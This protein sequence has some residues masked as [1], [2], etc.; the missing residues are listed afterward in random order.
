[1]IDL[2]GEGARRQSRAAA[3]ID[4]APEE[5]GLAGRVAR[6]QH[7][8]E[9]Q[10]GPTIAEIVDQRSLEFRR[11]LIEQRAHIGRRHRRQLFGAEPHQPK[12]RAVPVV[13]IGVA[14]FAEGRDR[15]GAFAELSTDFSKRKP[16]GGKAGC[17]IGRLNQEIGG[18]SK[19]ALELEIARELKPPVGNQIAGGQE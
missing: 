1:M 4:G 12:A 6:G 5:S 7:R 15:G 3:E 11:I 18:G 17:E 2:L 8:L 10:R 9:Q 13:G 14:R 19:V 16:R